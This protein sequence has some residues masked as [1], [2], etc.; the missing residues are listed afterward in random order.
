MSRLKA[1]YPKPLPPSAPP[2]AAAPLISPVL[3]AVATSGERSALQ[4][5]YP[6]SSGIMIAAYLVSVVLVGRVFD[7][8]LTG[9]HLPAII[10]VIA[11]ICSLISGKL[12]ALKN[13]VGIPLLC[14]IGWMFLCTPFSTWRGD[15]A[16]TVM[17][18]SFYTLMWLPISLGPRNFKD[19]KRIIVLLCVLNLVTLLLTKSTAGRLEGEVGSFR[20]SE[21]IALI[22]LLSVPFWGLLSSFFRLPALKVIV[23]ATSVFFLLYTTASTGARAGIVSALGMGLFYF[24][25]ASMSKKVVLVVA[26]VVAIPLIAILLPAQ[27][28]QRLATIGDAISNSSTYHSTDDEAMGS[29]VSRH[30]LL[31][32]SIRITLQHPLFGVG[33]GQFAEF[34]WNE[35]HRAVGYLVTHNAYTE[36]SSEDGIPGLLFFCALLVGTF[37]VIRRAKRLNA[38]G[39][40]S[41]WQLGQAIATAL[42]LGLINL[43]ICGFFMANS[44]YIFWYLMGGLGLALER[45]TLMAI[46]RKPPAAPSTL[47]QNAAFW[48]A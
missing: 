29:A 45:V 1:S 37:L 27:T 12:E 16:I 18:F 21:D 24:W 41:Q 13:Q 10:C 20:N 43:V 39:S 31:L 15:S 19:L 11:M 2:R 47:R 35:G 42:Q 9:F 17:Y 25:N 5:I 30:L 26:L 46:T 23:G 14:L 34:R 40:H 32:D 7:R 8:V 22:S 4:R 38:P 28:L 3:P 36:M 48:G 33:P 6:G 44:D